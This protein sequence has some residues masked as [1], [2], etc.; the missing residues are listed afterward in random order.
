MSNNWEEELR[1]LKLALKE[2][3]GS[4]YLR[5]EIS[6]VYVKLKRIEDAI[7]IAEDVADEF[8]DYEPALS[9]LATLYTNVKNYP[10]AIDIYKRMLKITPESIPVYLHLSYLYTLDSKMNKAIET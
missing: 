8:S 7:Q 9:L 2:D 4:A 6:Q 5:I 1:N 10:K 3:P